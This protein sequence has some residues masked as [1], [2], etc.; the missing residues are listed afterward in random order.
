MVQILISTHLSYYINIYPNYN[1]II[2]NYYTNIKLILL[3]TNSIGLLDLNYLMGYS[4]VISSSYSLMGSME[5]P[6]MSRTGRKVPNTDNHILLTIRLSS[7]FGILL[8]RWMHLKKWGYSSLSLGL[9]DCPSLGLSTFYAIL[10]ICKLI[11]DKPVI[12]WSNPLNTIKRKHTS[13]KHIHVSIGLYYPSIPARVSLPKVWWPSSMVILMES[14]EW[15]EI[16]L[17]DFYIE[18]NIKRYIAS[19]MKDKQNI[20][21]LVCILPHLY[22]FLPP[23]L[24]FLAAYSYYFSFFYSAAFCLAIF[25]SSIY[26][27]TAYISSFN[28]SCYCLTFSTLAFNWSNSVVSICTA[29]MY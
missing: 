5:I 8:P 29:P 15:N 6:S 20:L 2:S 18:L 21:G 17:Y 25:L 14:G 28:L 10:G 7:I 24:V 11:E 23:F 19:K 27:L 22:H 13:Q 9:K 12:S 1:I 26:F 4:H 16:H 3:K